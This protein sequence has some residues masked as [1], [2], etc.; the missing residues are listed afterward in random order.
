MSDVQ[1]TISTL[2][3]CLESLTFCHLQKEPHWA[4]ARIVAQQVIDEFMND[5]GP[6]LANQR[7]ALSLLAAEFTRRFPDEV[8]PVLIR[9]AMRRHMRRVGYEI[10]RASERAQEMGTASGVNAPATAP[11]GEAADM[12][13]EAERLEIQRQGG[14]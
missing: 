5:A 2:E 14:A 3:R 7:D 9:S 1:P 13:A 4:A 12:D 11:A 6:D 8:D 10:K